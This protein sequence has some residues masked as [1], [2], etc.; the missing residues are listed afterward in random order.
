MTRADAKGPLARLDEDWSTRVGALTTET[1]VEYMQTNAF[2][3]RLSVSGA[4]RV[5]RRP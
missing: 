1:A 5:R 4:R 3:G 2:F